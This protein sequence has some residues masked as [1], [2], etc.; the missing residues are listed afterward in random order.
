M[1]QVLRVGHMMGMFP[2]SFRDEFDALL[3]RL[4]G[5]DP[6]A[7]HGWPRFVRTE[8]ASLK[9]SVHGAGPYTSRAMRQ[10]VESL[11]TSRTGHQ[12][13]DDASEDSALTL[14]LLCRG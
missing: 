12:P 8:S 2:S 13:L 1:Q 9:H 6:I 14:C 10:V 5:S 7:E 11:C 4:R 3:D